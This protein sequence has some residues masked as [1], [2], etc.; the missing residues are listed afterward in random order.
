MRLIG[1]DGIGR[2]IYMTASGRRIVLLHAF[3]KKTRKTPVR[4]PE[5]ARARAKEVQ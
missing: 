1:R 3:V 5:I 2:I 4:A